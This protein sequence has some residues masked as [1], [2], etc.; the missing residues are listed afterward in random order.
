MFVEIHVIQNFPAANLNRD[1]TG[2]PKD[3]EFGGH[4]RARVSSQCWKRSVREYFSQEALVPESH[5]AV[6][7]KRLAATLAER[8]AGLDSER[9]PEQARV[10]ASLAV[11][12][13]GTKWDA[14]VKE[15]KRTS[16]LLFLGNDQVDRLVGL[17]DQY[18]VELLDAAKMK[19]PEVSKAL[20]K[21][22]RDTLRESRAVDLALFGRMIA[23][24]ADKN[25][26]AACQVAHAISTHRV[27]SEFDYFTAV[28][29]LGRKEES[30]A[31]MIGT[32]E[33]NS[34]CF[35]RYAN[36]SIAQLEANLGGDRELALS[37]LRVFL[38]SFIMAI[39]RAKQTG[40][41]AQSLPSFVMV[42]VRE[43]GLASLAN[44]FSRPV[45]GAGPGLTLNSVGAMASYY[46]RLTEMYGGEGIRISVFATVEDS[47]FPALASAGVE[48]ARNVQQLLDVALTSVGESQR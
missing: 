36:V 16:V 2:A 8:L 42:V 23:E 21:Q 44:A 7:T 6:R 5:L 19:K 14:K 45:D 41:A 9:K 39:P 29:D 35:Y 30:G 40:S 17:C 15:E 25:V 34:A 32:Q 1:D 46:E 47:E 37:G 27:V 28:D 3:C 10:V 20:A 33:F 12:A 18:W 38:Q 26:D 11:E 48:R 43:R 13:L 24:D 4:R 31:G 22:F